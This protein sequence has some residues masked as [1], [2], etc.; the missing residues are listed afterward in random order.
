VDLNWGTP[1]LGQTHQDVWW[2]AATAAYYA[3]L[4]VYLSAPLAG[5]GGFIRDAIIYL[6]F[7]LTNGFA[8]V[9]GNLAGSLGWVV[10]DGAEDALYGLLPGWTRLLTS[11]VLAQAVAVFFAS[12]IGLTVLAWG[13]DLYS[14]VLYHQ[15]I[16]PAAFAGDLWDPRLSG[17]PNLN[18]LAYRLVTA[19]LFLLGHS[20]VWS[21]RRLRPRHPALT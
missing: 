20:L 14:I 11:N 2:Q 13:R 7:Y 19:G 8:V 21:V 18:P 17:L 1:L 3:L 12:G 10:I 9:P 15:S 5:A 4:G 6:G 16:S